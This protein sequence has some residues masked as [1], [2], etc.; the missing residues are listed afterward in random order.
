[1][2]DEINIQKL[3]EDYNNK[4]P[5]RELSRKLKF[6]RG[7]IRKILTENRLSIRDSRSSLIAMNHIKEKQKIT[8]SN[9]EKAYL[10]GLVMG[11]LTPVRKSGYTLKLI[12]HSTHRTFMDLLQKT[13]EMYGITNYKET[14]NQNMYRF[15]THI[16]LDSFSFLLHSKNGIIPNWINSDSFFDFLA[17][18]IDSDG[19]VIIRKSGKYFQYVIRLFGQNLEL[20]NEIKLRL[21]SLGYNLSIHKNHKIGD[22][23]YNNG[24]LFK[25]NKDYY[26]LETFKKAQ[27]LDLLNK[28]PI[29][30]PEKIAKKELI[31]KIQKQGGLHWQNVEKEVKELKLK[32]KQTVL[33]KTTLQN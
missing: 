3:L 4:I 2:N 13:F 16:D 28:I 5:I 20:L 9:T 18:F 11:D 24:I 29:R 19:S 12:T 33:Q 22:K 14:K 31:F 32:I 10:Y 27:T 30:H 1:M 8:L 6:S 15:Q 17:G 7:Y 21:E 23:I 26:A 25:Y